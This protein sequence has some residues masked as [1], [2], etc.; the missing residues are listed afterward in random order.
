MRALVKC[1]NNLAIQKF[2]S[3]AYW[4]F[5]GVYGYVCGAVRQTASL[6]FLR[7]KVPKKI[8]RRVEIW[9]SEEQS[10]SMS[11]IIATES[12]QLLGMV[13]RTALSH[14]EQYYTLR[15]ARYSEA[16]VEDMRRRQAELE[17]STTWPLARNEAAIRLPL[18]LPYC[19][20][21]RDVDA[22]RYVASLDDELF[23]SGS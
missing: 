9:M 22:Y 4:I 14:E 23:G 12:E 15:E 11:R 8:K 21:S 1:T 10:L 5:H 6:G 20:T 18:D 2:M 17:H 13:R 16:R 7:S 3:L 19:S